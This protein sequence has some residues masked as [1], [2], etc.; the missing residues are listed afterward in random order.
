M[1]QETAWAP[2]IEEV[3][4]TLFKSS[5]I[6]EQFINC[7]VDHAEP[8]STILECGFGTGVTLELLRDL[9][10]DVEGIDLEPLA[11]EKAVDR[12]P[13][14]RNRVR[15]GDLKNSD[16]YEDG[17]DIIIHQ[18]VMEHFH[19]NEIME[20]LSLQKKKCKKIIFD[21]PNNL[22]KD[23]SDEGVMTRFES[24]KF[25]ENIISRC[26]L[27]YKRYGRTL[28]SDNNLLPKSLSHYSSDL[29]KVVGRSSIFVV[30]G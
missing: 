11:I 18:G 24:P 20:I 4:F 25:W 19:D 10:Y 13:H 28:D 12:F 5:I 6:Q 29:M 9:K 3:R 17:Y 22:R 27:K 14:L 8:D 2:W 15:V 30:E 7:I 21:V 16:S 23:Q 1:S 26:G